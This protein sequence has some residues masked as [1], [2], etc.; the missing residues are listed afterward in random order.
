MSL[1]KARGVRFSRGSS[2]ATYYLTR[3]HRLPLSTADYAT[4]GSTQSACV[5]I[6]WGD[7]SVGSTVRRRVYSLA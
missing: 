4:P 6:R 2:L 3:G 7:L 1:N 5:G